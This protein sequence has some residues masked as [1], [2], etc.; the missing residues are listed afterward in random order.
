MRTIKD[1]EFFNALR[2]YFK[3]YLPKQKQVSPNTIRSYQN[4]MESLLDYTVKANSIRLNEITFETIDKELIYSYLDWLENE[5]N[6]SKSTRNHRLR[7][8][9]AFY[10][11]VADSIPTAVVYQKE[12]CKVRQAPI[13]K[14]SKLDYMS[15][16]AVK[17]ILAVPDLKTSKGVRDA[18][19]MIMLYDTGAR[20]QEVLDIK[21]C[22]IQYR[23]ATV[24][25]HGKGR[26]V[27]CVTLM[28]STMKHL[29]NYIKLFHTDSAE[30][31]YLFFTIRKAVKKQMTTDNARRIVQHYG[32]LAKERCIAVPENVHPHLF[33]HSRAMHLYQNGMPLALISQWLGHSNV[34]TTLIYAYADTEMKRKAI[35]SATPPESPLKKF[36]NSERYTISDE[37]LIKQLY[38]LR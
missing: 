13:E 2:E 26:K 7:C 34:E 37:E 27:R 29:H 16:E 1:T 18:L 32:S 9:K 20:I 30:S 11:F 10:A 5:C 12:I 4:A 3:V 22:D 24:T 23:K 35:E 31:E 15:E 36:L 21:L 8:I 38:G 28:D 19:I 14:S 33:R 25:L 6:C 17:A